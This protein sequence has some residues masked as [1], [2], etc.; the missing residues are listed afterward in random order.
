[1]KKL[2]NS[3][4]ELIED[5]IKELDFKYNQNDEKILGEIKKFWTQVAGDKISTFSKVIDISENN[6][7]TIVCSDSFVANELYLEKQNLL[8][9]MNK[10][11]QNLGIIIKDIK[12]NYKRWKEEK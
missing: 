11:V 6:I 9:Y 4:F 1:M 10:N 8:K 5:V 3:N 2:N 12:F 7:L